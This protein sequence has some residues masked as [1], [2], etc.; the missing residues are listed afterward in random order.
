MIRD[1]F[2]FKDR[3]EYKETPIT[4]PVVKAEKPKIS[5][6]VW[7]NTTYSGADM[8][9]I[10]HTYGNGDI[11]EDTYVKHEI[12]LKYYDEKINQLDNDIF[13]LQDKIENENQESDVYNRLRKELSR[14]QKELSSIE[15][16][17]QQ[18]RLDFNRKTKK[19][20]TPQ[21]KVLAEIQTL[22]VSTSREKSEVR[23]F[24]SVYPKGFVRGARYISGT[25]IFTVFNRSVLYTFLDPFM[26]DFDAV[27]GTTSVLV[28]QLPPMD[29]S[30][31]FANEYGSMSKMSILGVE[32]VDD[33]QVMSIEDIITENTI[34]FVARDI[35]PMHEA[36]QMKLDEGS[37]KA[38][39]NASKKASDLIKT[40]EYR[41]FKDKNSVF[42]FNRRRTPF[43]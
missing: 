15:K 38:M 1:Q 25:M 20:N 11:P 6:L 35:D 33:G 17:A 40:N 42:R 2:V 43:L 23:S 37:L 30:I 32:F 24:G 19:K 41:K 8:K 28:D 5:S 26:N 13:A 14:R 21:T 27:N 10:I 12:D 3:Y 34:S 7:N 16:S 36:G 9:V 22:S 39:Q 31:S 29:I 18:I 4:P